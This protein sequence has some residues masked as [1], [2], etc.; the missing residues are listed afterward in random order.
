MSVRPFARLG[1][2]V[3]M[4]LVFAGAM[5]LLLGALGLFVYVRF[6]GSLDR[7]LDQ[8]LR[9]R[10]EDVRALVTQADSG[11][12][13]TGG[14]SL[15]SPG[16]RFAQIVRANGSVLDATAGLPARPL[17]DPPQL[18]RSSAAPT[19]IARKAIPGPAGSSRLL[20]IPVHAQDRRVIVV[21]GASLRQRD[22]ALADLRT[23]LLLGGPVALALASLLGYAVAALA[24]RSVESMR[25]RALR[26]SL[27]EPGRRL[28]VPPG[29]DELARLARTLNEMLARNEIAFGRERAFVAD[30]S[31]ELRSP[32]AILRAELDVALMGESSREELRGAVASAAEEADRLS[33]LAEDL[34]MLAA[35]DQGNLPINVEPVE[36]RESLRRLSERFEQRAREAGAAID[37][38]AS[39]GL[40]VR[41]DPLRLEQ[42]LGNL[43]EN[44]LH[45][46]AHHVLLRAER[47]GER[48]ELHVSDDGPGFPTAF[49][50]IA[51]ERFSRADP[52]RTAAGAG[53]GLS[54]VRS[55][56][57][58]H[59]GDAFISNNDRGGAD[60]W[61]SIP[62]APT[63]S[64]ARLSEAQSSRPGPNGPV[65]SAA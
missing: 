57:R 15:A 56:A 24:L 43:L 49:L 40:E 11:L 30:A 33:A 53:L 9:S 46:G 61:L 16:E 3:K 34:L 47:H 18:I 8:G 10:A 59:G 12:R 21:V 22:S 58:A 14:S 38:Q 64:P 6:E 42:A 45:H 20:A 55:I 65:V 37:T 23:V 50:Q 7:S 35:A 51:F 19:L 2:R 4:T 29:N 39:P 54:I 27:F 1:L 62:E 13:Q 44:A 28:P 52:S 31:H 17:L 36:V 26:V 48:L 41:A 32:L 25:R 5:S 63:G 60:V